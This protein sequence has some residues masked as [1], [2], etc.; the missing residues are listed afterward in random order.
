ME[1]HGPAGT[2]HVGAF[3]GRLIALAGIFGLGV[4]VELRGSGPYSEQQ[5]T[6]LY[7]L[8]LVG[9]LFALAWGVLGVYGRRSRL[10]LAA[11][12]ASDGLL[13]TGFVYCSGGVHSFFGFLYIIWV[14]HAA[15][16]AD[17]RLTSWSAIG[18]IA[19]YGAMALGTAM[20]WIPTFASTPPPLL[21]EAATAFGLHTAAVLSVSLLAQ[22]QERVVE[23]GQHELMEL[24]EIHRRIVDNVSSGLLT[25]DRSECV[26]SF[27]REAERITG[28]RAEEVLGRPL[29]QLFPALDG[30]EATPAQEPLDVAGRRGEATFRRG[31]GDVLHLGFSR[32]PLLD[33]AGQPEGGVLIFQDL[34]RVREME[35]LLRRSER[36]SVVGQLATGLAHEIRNPLASLSGAIELLG[37]DL[38]A[39]DASSRRL[40]RIVERETARLNRLVSDFLSYAT[41]REPR[42][43]VV[44]LREL[45]DEIRDL[46]STGEYAAQSLKLEIEPGLAALGDP[47][48]LR[49]VFWNLILNA[50]QAEPVDACVRVCAV[51]VRDAEGSQPCVRVDVH[52]RGAGIPPESLER[53]FEPFFTTKAKGTGLGLATVYRVV[54]A[55]G[56]ELR[57]ASDPG[58]GTTA[59]VILDRAPT[60]ADGTAS[61]AAEPSTMES[62]G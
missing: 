6:G 10:L 18:A 4:M 28:R 22:R 3:A 44:P 62:R 7:A 46:W 42:R 53:V 51:A 43:T 59:S 21:D 26:T 23:A 39:E 14:V 49:Q 57:L 45:F 55:H 38:R 27:N 36:L 54:E 32:S 11:E 8:V 15:A 60:D 52:D 13:V 25:V 2:G 31:D 47:D 50:A 37:A 34:T 29:P 1:A 56:G 17:S 24:G 41:G 9:F 30:L 61:P 48:Q 35:E 58:R 12:L 40:V 33:A 16:R 5:I 19:A 20:E